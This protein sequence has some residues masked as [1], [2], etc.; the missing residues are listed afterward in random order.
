MLNSRGLNIGVLL[1]LSS[2]IQEMFYPLLA[3]FQPMFHFYT[4][5]NIGKPEVLNGLTLVL[6]SL[7]NFHI[8][9]NVFQIQMLLTWQLIIN[10][11]LMCQKDL[12]YQKQ[13]MYVFCK[14]CS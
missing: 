2:T 10:Q 8:S 14:K 5:E 11:G 13:Q 6:R 7:N 12:T 4:P 1:Q 3:H 9:K